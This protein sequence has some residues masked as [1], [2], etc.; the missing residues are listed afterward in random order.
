MYKT[1]VKLLTNIIFVIRNTKSVIFLDREKKIANLLLRNALTLSTAES[2]TGGLISSRMTDVSGSSAYISQN[3]VTYANT[4]KI[5][6]LGV[7]RETIDKYGVV[8]EE[9]ALEMAKGLIDKY[10]CTLAISTTGIAGPLGATDTKPVGMVCIAVA[11]EENQKLY[12]YKANPLLFRRIMKY[13]FSN[14]ALDFL[15]E[16]LKENY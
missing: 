3:F 12:T 1:I 7:K 13:A 4:A 8:S 11:D 10:D 6:L 9:V 5:K 15:L 16:F 2:C 14:K